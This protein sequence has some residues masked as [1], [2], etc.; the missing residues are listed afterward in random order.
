MSTSKERICQVSGES[1]RGA[2]SSK[3]EAYR[4]TGNLERHL[5]SQNRLVEIFNYELITTCTVAFEG[6]TIYS[7]QELRLF[8]PPLYHSAYFLISNIPK[9]LHCT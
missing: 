3:Q 8:F 4:G 5:L 1:S 2:G 9:L 7:Q 6:N